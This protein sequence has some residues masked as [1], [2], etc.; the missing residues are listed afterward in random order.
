[1]REYR[2]NNPDFVERQRM[3]GKEYKKCGVTLC[4]RC[5]IKIHKLW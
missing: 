2:K 5:H 3:K 4:G 1:M